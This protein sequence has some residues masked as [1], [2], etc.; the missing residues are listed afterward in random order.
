MPISAGAR[1]GPYEILAKL[2]EGGMGEVYKA[3]DTR[4]NRSVA[5]KVLPDVFANDPDRLA[6]FT[7]EAQTLASL[8]HTNIAQIHGLEESAGVRA[9]V[10]EL[11]DGEDLSARVERGPI[12]LNEA[13]PILKQIADALQAAH[14]HGVV[15]RDLKPANIKIRPDGTVKVL[16]FGLAKA[17]EPSAPAADL[18]QSP[19]LTAT[20]AGMILGTA[21]YMSPE[22][23]RGR[24]VDQRTDIWAFGCV[25]YEM[26]GGRPAFSGDTVTDILSAI[27]S[28][29][30]DW[31]RLPPR[32]PIAI[33]RL[34]RRCLVKDPSERLHSIADARLELSDA[35][36]EPTVVN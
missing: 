9:L 1:L 15:H 30:P 28:R 18:S 13:V 3:R 31:T 8:N 12:P 33:Q 23:A 17:M 22:Q 26:L 35:R 25:A 5:L 20:R 4:L 10:M 19:T 7:R 14:E 32:T 24:T 2:G 34:F 36:N 27:V 11:V 6:R 29:D 16:D 21:A